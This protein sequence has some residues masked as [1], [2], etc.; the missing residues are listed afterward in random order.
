MHQLFNPVVS[1]E[2]VKSPNFIDQLAAMSFARL[3]AARIREVLSDDGNRRAAD[4]WKREHI[5]ESLKGGYKN[6]ET[7]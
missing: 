3:L 1:H 2:R 4:A 7:D 5:V 6:G